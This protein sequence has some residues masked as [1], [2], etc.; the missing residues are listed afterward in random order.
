MNKTILFCIITAL[1]LGN[2]NHTTMAEDLEDTPL[3][4][5]EILGNYKKSVYP[6][7]Q[8]NLLPLVDDDTFITNLNTLNLNEYEIIKRFFRKIAKCRSY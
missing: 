5:S 3:G 2:F 4:L 1:I 6:K 7:I 8:S